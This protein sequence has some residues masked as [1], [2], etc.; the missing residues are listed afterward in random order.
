MWILT[1]QAAAGIRGRVTWLKPSIKCSRLPGGIRRQETRSATEV[2]GNSPKLSQ[3]LLPGSG[4]I[5][6]ALLHFPHR[7]VP[8]H[9]R[10]RSDRHQP[11]RRSGGC[12]GDRRDVPE[13]PHHFLLLLS[14]SASATAVDEDASLRRTACQRVPR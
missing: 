11:K 10:Q 14:G 6:S 7:Y 8:P 9:F 4:A 13:C 12:H 1:G 2:Q 5:F 3:A